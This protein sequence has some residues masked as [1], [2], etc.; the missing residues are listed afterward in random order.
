VLVRE[1]IATELAGVDRRRAAAEGKRRQARAAVMANQEALA[2]LAVARRTI[3]DEALSSIAARANQLLSEAGVDLSLEVSWMREVRGQLATAC[4]ACGSP[5]PASQRVKE[6]G[7]GA[8][9]GPKQSEELELRVSARSGAA[10]DLAGLVFCLAAGAWL[11]ER[12]SSGW[13][14]CFLDEPAGALDVAHKRLLAAHVGAML[15][16]RHGF[17]QAFVVAHEQ[18]FTDGLPGSIVIRA[19][20]AGSTVEVVR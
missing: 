20:A 17:S 14:V 9:R 12:R 8:E 5:F 4:D 11:R 13:G 6:C 16:T 19:T 3:A 18:G 2:V 1:R 10:D 7:C 15:S